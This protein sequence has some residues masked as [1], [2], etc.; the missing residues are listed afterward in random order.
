MITPLYIRRVVQE[1]KHEHTICLREHTTL[2]DTAKLYLNKQIIIHT[3]HII[4]EHSPYRSTRHFIPTYFSE[5]IQC[6]LANLIR[7]HRCHLEDSADASLSHDLLLIPINITPIYWTIL[8]R[9]IDGDTST[10]SYDS[11]PIPLDITETEQHMRHYFAT[12][13]LNP[14]FVHHPIRH[15]SAVK[16]DDA[17]NCGMCVLTVAIIYLYFP[18]PGIFPWYS[19]NYPTTA[20]H[21]HNVIIAML[22]TDIPPILNINTSFTP[23]A[24]S[25]LP[26]HLSAAGTPPTTP[27][28][29]CLAPP[30]TLSSVCQPQPNRNLHTFST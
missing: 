21:M 15:V 7:I 27:Q 13:G 26:T 25:P 12:V 16:Q 8:V 1:L 4:H 14:G 20:T 11:L 24:L 19:L 23:A 6:S 3:L 18:N 30:T 5:L 2:Y 29:P 28:H 22:Q 9:H 17:Y 10:I